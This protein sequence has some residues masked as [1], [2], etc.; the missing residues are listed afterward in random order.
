MEHLIQIL[1][2]G[3]AVGAVYGVVALGFVLIYK[4]TGVLN[5]AQGQLVLAG[6]YMCYGFAGQLGLPFWLAAIMTMGASLLLGLVIERIF[7][8]P[9]I[10]QPLLAVVMLT[11]GLAAILDGVVQFIWGPYDHAY[12]AYLPSEPLMLGTAPVSPDYIW[13]AVLTVILLIAFMLYFRFTKSGLAMRATAESQQ[14]AKSLGIRVTRVNATAWAISSLTAAAGGIILA[15]IISVNLQL[16]VSGLKAIPAVIVGGLE[17][18]PGAIVGGLIIG[19]AEALSGAYLD[20]FFIGIKEVAPYVV[21]LIIL[22]VRPH[23]IF[24]LK[25]IE[26]V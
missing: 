11:I 21:L 12:P 5:I 20:K 7:L 22:L 24:G 15:T 23:G 6:A 17:S 19:L 2:I 4:A 1:V 8:R 3:V 10:G 26:R 25:T 14:V 13:G 18:L 9:M 16:S